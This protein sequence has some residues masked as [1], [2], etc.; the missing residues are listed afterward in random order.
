[1]P[2]RSHRDKI[3]SEG[4]KVVHARGFTNSSVRDIVQAAGVPQGSFT[5]HFASKEA[6]GL[7]LIDMYAEASRELIDA[8]LRDDTAPPLQ[9]L[10]DY[11]E[12][13]KGPA[14]ETTSQDDG[15]HNGCL[16]GNFAAESSDH[17]EA[18][19]NRVLEELEAV[20][21]S[22][23]YCLRAA[24]DAGELERS[25]DCD[26][27]A[28]FIVSS[29]QGAHLLAK[30]ERNVAPIDRFRDLLFSLVLPKTPREALVP[31]PARAAA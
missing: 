4:M 10:R 11:V 15:G 1:M 7:E 30:A 26:Q 31:V 23:A 28:A 18:I 29:L 8:T 27:L 3:L 13:S 5:N 24:V 17:S 6:F 19:R 12:G 25:V 2:K 20:R 16:L 21:R 14:C 9:R 22:L